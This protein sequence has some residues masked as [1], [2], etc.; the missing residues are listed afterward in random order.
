[1]PPTPA[2]FRLL[3]T[4][5]LILAA[6]L[7]VVMATTLS[8][9]TLRATGEE[10]TEREYQAAVRRAGAQVESWLAERTRTLTLFAGLVDTLAP[11]AADLERP[12]R[13]L[14]ALHSE[15]R[16]SLIL[17]TN[18]HVVARGGVPAVA[19]AAIQQPNP[20]IVG[21]RI[22]VRFVAASTPNERGTILIAVPIH[23]AAQ[24][25]SGI[26]AA[27][28]DPTTHTAPLVITESTPDISI[29]VTD[30]SGHSIASYVPQREADLTYVKPYDSRNHAL[31][32]GWRIVAAS[33]PSPTTPALNEQL[34]R[35]GLAAIM[36]LAVTLGLASWLLR[37]ALR[38]P[39]SLAASL[40]AGLTAIASGDL[41][42]D[43][44]REAPSQLGA[45]NVLAE[46]R[47]RHAVLVKGTRVTMRHLLGNTDTATQ[48]VDRL[49]RL[50]NAAGRIAGDIRTLARDWTTDAAV[51]EE[52]A[53]STTQQIETI[54]QGTEQG[55]LDVAETVRALA[56]ISQANQKVEER[57][58]AI[59]T[60][61]FQT[62]LLALNAAVEAA[63]AGEH[64]KGFAVVANEVRAL[65]QQSS[66]SVRTIK[67]LIADGELKIKHGARVAESAAQTWGSVTTSAKHLDKRISALNAGTVE[68]NQR[69]VQ[70][71]AGLQQLCEVTRASNTALDPTQRAI[72]SLQQ[73][74]N[75]LARLVG[76]YKL[77][78]SPPASP[79]YLPAH[80]ESGLSPPADT[81]T[82]AI[83]PARRAR[84]VIAAHQ[85][86][87]R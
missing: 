18:G 19:D 3:V 9:L 26:L 23:N 44:P 17:D 20:Q 38:P 35:I 66:H 1:M 41:S 65:A 85:S 54:L 33:A 45:M 36:A 63:R 37:A 21:D 12:L 78:A 49:Q 72:D 4:L 83:S 22:G 62:H 25:L 77:P 2:R 52:I 34:A 5:A 46:V 84:Q 14:H 70:L 87:R 81:N 67:D 28:F 27:T 13:R 71:N 31:A 59:E 86:A 8:F 79:E 15:L 32:N 48:G 43:A 29:I 47:R 56:N 74:L 55:N 42:A 76:G 58:N 40:F 16:S 80:N 57:L 51:C 82:V 24:G 68:Q 73:H 60:I 30:E 53:R 39:A 7:P 10:Y 75:L 50:T 69:S 61:A 6:T 11:D 64:S